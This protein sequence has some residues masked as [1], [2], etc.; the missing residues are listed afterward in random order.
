MM[1]AT[2]TARVLLGGTMMGVLMLALATIVVRDAVVGENPDADDLAPRRIE[3]DVQGL[4]IDPRALDGLPTDGAAWDALDETADALSEGIDPDLNERND[5]NTVV[6]AAA[7]VAVREDD[8]DLRRDVASAIDDAVDAT[9]E[10]T[11]ALSVARKLVTYVVAADLIHLGDV[12]PSD[13]RAFRA[14]LDEMRHQRSTSDAGRSVVS[15]HEERPN[16]WGTH[17]GASRIA[18]ALYLEDEKDLDR[19]ADV[20]AGWLGDRDRYAGFEYGDLSWQCDPARPVAV[21]PDGCTIEGHD[22]G[23]V[24]PDDQRRAGDFEWPPDRENYVW[25]ALQGAVVQAELLHRAGYDAWEWG[26]QAL[27]RAMTWLHEEADYPAEG[28]DTWIP[29]LVNRGTGTRFPAITPSEPGKN[30]GYTDWTH[31]G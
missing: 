24:L 4:W 16:N 2:R 26:D 11:D 13:D 8:D 27:V 19:A 22:V 18:A 3:R 31:T 7:L 25:E 28:D 12:D 1:L 15:T 21:N 10:V 29:W 23:G 14:W 30:L 9:G 6:L 17:A 20:F 5:H